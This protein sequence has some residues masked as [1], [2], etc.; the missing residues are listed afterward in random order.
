MISESLIKYRLMQSIK[1][2]RLEVDLLSQYHLSFQ[3]NQK[4]FRL[5]IVDSEQN[6]CLRME[7]YHL[8]DV[9]STYDLVEQLD[10]LFEDHTLLKAGYWKSITVAIKDTQFSLIPESLFEKDYIKEY[11]SL[12]SSVASSPATDYLYFKQNQTDAINIF[13]VDK[14]LKKWFE[15]RYPTRS[16]Q[17]IH[18]TA[19]MIEGILLQPSVSELTPTVYIQVEQ[20][21]LTIV[22]KKGDQ[23][24]FCNS[25]GFSS[26]EDFVYFVLFVFDQLQLNPETVPVKIWGEI[27]PDSD[28][29]SK[30][31]RYI[32]HI[33]FGDKPSSLRFSYQFDDI[34]EHR[35]FDLFSMHL[36]SA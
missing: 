25:F 7:D 12:T 20:Y 17:F 4:I 29:F 35:Y 16:V 31:Y 19:S 3:I 5:C 2:D 26:S 24:L 34:F 6:R 27:T 28:S 1:D 21:F 8:N 32:R 18:H 10:L 15:D 11:L 14:D 22:V 23:L 9:Y 30:L 33:S 13:S 36:C